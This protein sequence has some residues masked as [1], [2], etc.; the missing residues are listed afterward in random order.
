ML[1]E[2]V[3]YLDENGKLVTEGLRDFTRKALNGQPW[4]S[5]SGSDS[6]SSS[7]DAMPTMLS[8]LASSPDVLVR[9]FQLGLK[10]GSVLRTFHGSLSPGRIFEKL[11]AL[12]LYVLA[13]IHHLEPVRVV[14][15]SNAAQ[16]LDGL[17][18]LGFGFARG[19]ELHD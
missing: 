17:L 16:E 6:R 7:P 3:E 19:H 12:V 18:P 10:F 5:S 9:V 8:S 11:S 14:V 4:S 15:L 1:T 2:R 13:G